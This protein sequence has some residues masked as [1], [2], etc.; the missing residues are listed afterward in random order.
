M[1]GKASARGDDG[2]KR[3]RLNGAGRLAVI[4]LLSLA[5]L[6]AGAAATATH[7]AACMITNGMSGCA[8]DSLTV[9]AGATWLQGASGTISTCPPPPGNPCFTADWVENVYRENGNTA[10]CNYSG[11]LTWVVQVTSRNITQSPDIISRVNIG[12][13]SQFQTD[14]GVET[15][16]PPPGNPPFTGAGTIV[17]NTVER[18]ATGSVLRWHFDCVMGVNGCTSTNEI[19]PGQETVLLEVETNAKTIVPG[20]VSLQDQ[21]A[22]SQPAL[23]PAL[24]EAWVPALGAVGG[25]VIGVVAFRRRRRATRD[26]A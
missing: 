23:G 19:M 5:G 7:A 14:M 3:S 10:V 26:I 2:N 22:G 11:C 8:P 15:N 18:S 24:P 17:P 25:A 21:T 4:T 16:T 6:G 9:S 20:T 12:N 1:V 13:F